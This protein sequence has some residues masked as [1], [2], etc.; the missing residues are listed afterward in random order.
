MS[1]IPDALSK[2]N[3]LN[4]DTKN[5]TSIRL[6]QRSISNNISDTKVPKYVLHSKRLTNVIHTKLRHN[7]ILNYDIHR[8]NI[9]DF[10]KFI[11]GKKDVY[12]F[13]LVCNDF[14]MQK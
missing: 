10:P 12:N 11:C 7:C 5:A 2:S 3:S 1:F 14:G 6:F 4:S 13:L 8:R 9:I